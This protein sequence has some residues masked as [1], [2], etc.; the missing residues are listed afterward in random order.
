MNV[1]SGI[2]TGLGAIF[3]FQSIGMIFIGVVVGIIFGAIPGLTATMGIGLCL[4]LTFGMNPVVAMALLCGLYIGGISGGL[5]SAILLN[6]PGTPSSIATC[7]DGHPLAD[8]GEAGKALGVGIT[9]SFLGGLFSFLVLFLMAPPLANVALKFGPFEYFALAVFSLTLIASLAGESLAKGLASGLLG[10]MLAMFGMA[11]VDAFPRFTFGVHSLDNGFDMLPVLIGLFAISEIL[12]TAGMNETVK[13]KDIRSFK[14]KG[15]FGFSF[16]E[17]KANIWN[18]IRSSLI[19][20]GIGILPGIGGGTSNML[21]Y[22]CA[23]KSS[24]DPERFGTGIIDGIVASEAANNAS[25]GGALVPLL[26][27]GIPGDTVTAMLIGAFMIHGISPGPLLFQNNADLV[28]G[29]FASLLVA[30][31]IM[32][33]V[34]FLG[35]KLFVQ[36]LRVPKHYLLPII[37]SLCVVGAYGLNNRVFDVFTIFVFGLIAYGLKKFGYPFPPVILGF[38]LGP[39]LELNLR[40]GLMLTQGNFLPFLT[41]PIGAPFLMIALVVSIGTVR[42][43][44]KKRKAGNGSYART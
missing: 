36:V 38:I 12:E 26:T 24:K 6:I 23:K 21:S 40:R 4:P 14:I 41:S 16:A 29:I 35:L 1:I 8:K 11:P 17:F 5:I 20:M 32:L 22:I 2:A 18:F 37:L 7:F 15:L 30:N 27:L 43:N 31:V 42:Q 34:E 28:Y 25:I 39:M 13:E 33:V 44:M 3:N 10:F 9:Y 19:G